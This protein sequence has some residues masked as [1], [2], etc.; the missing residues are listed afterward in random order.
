[1]RMDVPVREEPEE[2]QGAVML[3]DVADDLAP[4]AALEDLPALDRLG[5]EFR[6]L[7]EDLPG[8]DRVMPDLGVPHI[9]VTRET[10]GGAVRTQGDHRIIPH[11][12]IQRRGVGGGDGVRRIRGSK[13]HA[14]HDD[15]E[16]GSLHTFEIL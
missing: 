16:E 12:A 9:V 2:M 15:G 7:G 13:P 14:V 4:C 11:Q 3:L 5:D 8:A 1:M 10:D 6:P